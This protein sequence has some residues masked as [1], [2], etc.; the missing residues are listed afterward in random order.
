MRSVLVKNVSDWGEAFYRGCRNHGRVPAYCKDFRPH[1]DSGLADAEA[2]VA[3][4][5]AAEALF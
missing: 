2:D 4:G 3:D 5:F 1:N